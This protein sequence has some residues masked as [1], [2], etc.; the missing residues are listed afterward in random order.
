[1]AP[2][3]RIESNGPQ[4][5]LS[6][7]NTT[8]KLSQFSWLGF[9][10]SF[11]GFNL[12][13]AKAFAKTFDGT[14]AKIGIVQIQVTEEFIAKAPSLPRKGE[15][16]FKN[17]KVANIPWRSLLIYKRSQYHVNGMSLEL[18]NT[19][20]HYLLFIINQFITYEGYGS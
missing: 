6:H 18:F 2:I 7:D 11:N 3:V 17:M 12:E 9:I 1:M 13:V 19:H 10:E 15:K 8:G 4:T 16:W 14:K 20:W 5:L